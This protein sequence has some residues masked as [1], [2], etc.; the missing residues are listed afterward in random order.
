M[1]GYAGLVYHFMQAFWYRFL[2]DAKL[3]ELKRL[4]R[5]AQRE[6]GAPPVDAVNSSQGGNESA[7]RL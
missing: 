3:D 4:S 1:D 6:A 5:A 2:V 7:I